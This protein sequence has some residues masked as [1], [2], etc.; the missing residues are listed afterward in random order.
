VWIAV[1]GPDGAGKSTLVA[2][3]RSE[4]GA[5]FRETAVFHLR[6]ALGR[7]QAAGAPVTDPH[8]PA[9]YPW[10][11]SALKVPY[12]VLLYNLSYLAAVRPRLRAGGLVLCDRYYDDLVADPRRYRYRGPLG[13]AAF[14]A[15]WTP[16]PDL[17]LI[18]DAPAHTLLRRKREVPWRELRRQRE[19]YRRLDAGG[20]RVFLLDA[21]RPEDEVVRDAVAAI[22]GY[23]AQ[24]DGRGAAAGGGAPR[25]GSPT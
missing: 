9:P 18:L 24:R 3:L 12:Y 1:L 5:A 20:S 14:G 23:L 16:R 15:R 7:R 21:A 6:P 22:R 8:A 13:L 10:W 4:L 19:A 17:M 11:L 25:E 2:R